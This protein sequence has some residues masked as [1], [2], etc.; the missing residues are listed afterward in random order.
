MKCQQQGKT[1][2]KVGQSNMCTDPSEIAPR[3]RHG[4]TAPHTLLNL[5]LDWDKLSDS[6]TDG[7]IPSNKEGALYP[8][9]RKA[10]RA[11]STP[12]RCGERRKFVSL[13]GNRV[14]IT[15]LSRV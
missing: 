5:A 10:G 9:N 12:A 1:P 3:C 7:S 8:P 13:T 6:H 15:M 2:Q 4:D 11:Y 14:S